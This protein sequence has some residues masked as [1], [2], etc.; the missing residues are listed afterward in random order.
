MCCIAVCRICSLDVDGNSYCF[1]FMIVGCKVDVAAGD[2]LT[3]LHVAVIRNH[4]DIVQIL[5]AAGSNINYKTHEKMTPL[6]FAASR[7]YLDLV[8]II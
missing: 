8:N 6:H 2:G 7:G 3:P 4:S 5:L 1:N